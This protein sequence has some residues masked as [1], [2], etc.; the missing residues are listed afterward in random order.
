MP[1]AMATRQEY[2]PLLHVSA[3]FT[4]PLHHLSPTESWAER[5]CLSMLS[6]FFVV[7]VFSSF[8]IREADMICL[9]RAVLFMLIILYFLAIVCTIECHISIRAKGPCRAFSCFMIMCMKGR[10]EIEYN[11]IDCVRRLNTCSIH[12]AL[13]LE[14]LD[15]HSL[16]LFLPEKK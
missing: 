10:P 11:T 2:A 12:P 5:L 1:T 13:I 9:A 14:T 7:V 3:L 4:A 6:C 16:P 15:F 8:L